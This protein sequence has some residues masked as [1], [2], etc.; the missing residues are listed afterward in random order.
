MKI[1]QL[2][3]MLT[4]TASEMICLPGFHT[5]VMPVREVANPE[6]EAGL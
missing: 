1:H 2:V 6:E 3:M 4:N 5:V